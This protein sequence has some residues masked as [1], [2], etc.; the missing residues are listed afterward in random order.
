LLAAD[1]IWRLLFLPLW[2]LLLSLHRD[3]GQHDSINMSTT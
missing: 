2:S 3:A 1:T